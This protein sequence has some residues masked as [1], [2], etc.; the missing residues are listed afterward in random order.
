VVE[1]IMSPMQASCGVRLR[2][3]SAKFP[4][5][6]YMLGLLSRLGTTR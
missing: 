5:S 4:L 2:F 1:R 6:L 3:L